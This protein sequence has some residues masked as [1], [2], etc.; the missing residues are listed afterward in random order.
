MKKLLIIFVLIL[1]PLISI[2]SPINNIEFKAYIVNYSTE[3]YANSIRNR[4]KFVLSDV[5]IRY[6][7]LDDVPTEHIMVME[8]YRRL[9]N[10]PVDKYYRLIYKE[11]RFNDTIKSKVGAH[12]YM[13]V[14]P[15][16]FDWIKST[17]DNLTPDSEY[18]LYGLT[19]NDPNDPIDNIKAGTFLLYWLKTNVYKRYPN[20]TE[21]YKWKRILASY[22]AGYGVHNKAMYTYSETVDYVDFISKR[23]P[24]KIKPIIKYIY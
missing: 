23:S 4:A 18:Y 15:T 1:L 21:S 19:I 13:Q 12:G 14:M 10:L 9:F 22:N 24:I 2:N 17:L 16:T 11:S 20:E 8:Q 7:K 3:T 6:L 5:N